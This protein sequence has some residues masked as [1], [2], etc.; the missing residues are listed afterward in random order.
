M[1]DQPSVLED[2]KDSLSYEE[3]KLVLVSANR[4]VSNE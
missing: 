2:G 3:Q 1:R 4:S